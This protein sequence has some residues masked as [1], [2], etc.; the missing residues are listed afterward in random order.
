MVRLICFMVMICGLALAGCATQPAAVNGLAAHAMNYRELESQVR[1]QHPTVARQLEQLRKSEDH[2]YMQQVMAGLPADM[3]QC[4]VLEMLEPSEQDGSPVVIGIFQTDRELGYVT[5][6][7][8]V[9]EESTQFTGRGWESVV[10]E[11]S[12]EEQG[13]A[14]IPDDVNQL[15]HQRGATTIPGALLGDS[16]VSAD[17]VLLVVT[18]V[19]RQ[20][21]Y[22]VAAIEGP[23]AMGKGQNPM[24][25]WVPP[26]VQR[27]WVRQH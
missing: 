23:E 9:D 8:S 19:D 16:K 20:R 15:L 11:L 4:L 10:W 13:K 22:S 21:V 26:S 18:Y 3:R 27:R 7:T 5:N 24:I 25:R 2:R 12:E 1:K 6:V 17:G 14:I